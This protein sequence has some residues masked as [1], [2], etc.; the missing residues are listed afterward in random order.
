M[1]TYWAKFATLLTLQTASWWLLFTLG[2]ATWW[3]DWVLK[4]LTTQDRKQYF[5]EIGRPFFYPIHLLLLNS[6]SLAYPVTTFAVSFGITWVCYLIARLQI[7]ESLA[8]VSA[9]FLAAMPMTFTRVTSIFEPFMLGLLT[10]FIAWYLM[11]KRGVRLNLFW[12][13]L[14]GALLFWSYTTS[15]LLVWVLMPM[16]SHFALINEKVTWRNLADYVTKFWLI[17]I[18]PIA[19]WAIDR[20]YFT[21]FGHYKNYNN[22]LKFLEEPR[23]LLFV[24]VV[25]ATLVSL[26]WYT[27][28]RFNRRKRTDFDLGLFAI[29]SILLGALP[30]LM[31][32]RHPRVFFGFSDRFVL[33]YTYGLALSLGLLV[34]WLATKRPWLS[35]LARVLILGAFVLMTNAGLSAFLLDARVQNEVVADLQNYKKISY[36]STVVFDNKAK[37]LFAYHRHSPYYEETGWLFRATGNRTHLGLNLGEVKTFLKYDYWINVPR[38]AATNYSPSNKAL[39][40]TIV[41]S[42]GA[43]WPQ[44]LFENKP[45][46]IVRFTRVRDIKSLSGR[47]E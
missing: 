32:G 10:F 46:V 28:R 31:I 45:A 38:Y 17:V 16:A 39:L 1:K 3:D 40:V 34:S 41:D 37:N 33:L 25:A 6:G 30:Y 21:P 19:F 4:S 35:K 42:P 13:L 24:A 15:S 47:R 43:G 18:S 26:A 27:I 12:Q 23:Q 29:F 9:C 44:S 2:G 11:L 5:T 20:V 8:F 14:V 7:R 22:P 36:S